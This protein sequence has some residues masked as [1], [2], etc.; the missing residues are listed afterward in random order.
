MLIKVLVSLRRNNNNIISKRYYISEISISISQKYNISR[1]GL[2]VCVR[3]K[4]IMKLL[5]K[6]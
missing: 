2:N 1:K 5:K 4:R 6:I 3:K